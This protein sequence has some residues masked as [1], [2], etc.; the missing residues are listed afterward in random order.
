M[1]RVL[2]GPASLFLAHPAFAFRRRLPFL[3]FGVVLATLVVPVIFTI[4]IVGIHIVVVAADYVACRELA[5]SLQ[6]L[7]GADRSTELARQV[8]ESGRK[9][10]KGVLELR[11]EAAG[12]VDCR[13]ELLF[14]SEFRS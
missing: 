11:D 2:G 1:F 5:R 12:P 14:S 4:D 7:V 10:E 6:D 9:F 8:L 13:D 3:L